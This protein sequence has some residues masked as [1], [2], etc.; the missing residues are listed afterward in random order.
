MAV[1]VVACAVTH[2]MIEVVGMCPLQK[3]SFAQHVLMQLDIG[4]IQ[5]RCRSGHNDCPQI[6]G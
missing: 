1:A 4:L 5:F 2:C 3:H 6:F